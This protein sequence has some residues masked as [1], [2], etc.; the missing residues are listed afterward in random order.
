MRQAETGLPDTL[1]KQ[2][3]EAVNT[4][5]QLAPEL[6]AL[7]QRAGLTLEKAAK[8]SAGLDAEQ[9][10]TKS[11]LS[12][13]WNGKR[14]VPRRK[15]ETL[16]ALCRVPL[17]QR[18][19]FVRA[20]E[21]AETADVAHPARGTLVENADARLLGVHASI[22][23]DGQT[24]D[25]PAYVT[26]D[27][28]E[29]IR[30][31]LSAAGQQATFVLLMGDSSTG[32]TRTLFEALQAVLPGWWLL[33]PGHPDQI[34]EVAVRP[35]A[36]TVLWLDELQKYL[37][38]PQRLTAA[39]VRTLLGAGVV[40]VASLWS[41]Y[42]NQISAV[43]TDDGRQLLRLAQSLLMPAGFS[44]AERA[45]AHQTAETDPRLRI[46][47]AAHDAG[48]TQTLA[49]GPELLMRWEHATDP[50]ATAVITAAVDARRLGMESPLTAAHLRD[51]VPGYLS[52]AQR[53][54]AGDDWLERA[55]A[56][57]TV[58]VHRAAGTLSAHREAMTGPPDGYRA[59][60]FL[61][62]QS[63][64]TRRT[65]VLP[66]SF[67]TV[68]AQH[69][70]NP[71]DLRRLAYQAD[72][73]ARRRHA[74]ALYERLA[75]LGDPAAASRLADL[76]A[77]E[78][79]SQAQ[80]ILRQHADDQ[81]THA[82]INH[83]RAALADL[84]GLRQAATGGD[85]VAHC[86]LIGVLAA[87]DLA[88]VHAMA[89]EGDRL[90]R[91]WLIDH[92]GGPE[93]RRTLL[94]RAER[95]DRIARGRLAEVLTERGHSSQAL[96]VLTSA[97]NDGDVLAA[98]HRAD[99]L[100]RLS[101]SAELLALAD[102]GDHAAGLAEDTRL[103]RGGHL[104]C[105]IAGALADTGETDQAIAVLQAHADGLVELTDDYLIDLLVH[106]ERL[107]LL[108]QIAATGEWTSNRR[109]AELAD[110][111]GDLDALHRMEAG[112]NWFA[113]SLLADRMLANGRV[114]EAI[115]HLSHR[116][117]AGDDF[118]KG[119]LPDLLAEHGREYEL[120]TL[121]RTDTWF[122]SGRWATYLAGTGR[123][124]QAEAWLRTQQGPG[125][126]LAASQLADLLV[127]QGR[128]DDALDVLRPFT[129][130]YGGAATHT[131]V[132]LLHRHGRIAE[133]R[134][135]VNAG[136][137]GAL[138]RLLQLLL[139]AGTITVAE[140]EQVRRRGLSDGWPDDNSEP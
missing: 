30:E 105:R 43:E 9:V 139:R 32:K 110:A 65:T 75:A 123:S 50:C 4:H 24:G 124:E 116:A 40:I 37:D 127:A 94:E 103:P 86:Q 112:G 6:R 87:N 136:T 106:L 2:R 107:D 63:F 79:M 53:A 78:D 68:L 135:E 96:A 109:L 58:L 92:D 20:W 69:A 93:H 84:D 77:A 3:L 113:T 90:A 72:A 41:G 12:A 25:L 16:L 111:R 104:A 125:E 60:D 31:L 100:V 14:P 17:Q 59:A 131:L 70:R 119:R 57:S 71:E 36:R 13:Y 23:V 128:I 117:S 47:V 66:T 5:G 15:L 52:S 11:A 38:G 34:R 64:R 138:E 42:Y 82:K 49:A 22:V 115:A 21:R 98:G 74:A 51:A 133:L 80:T 33:H 102:A 8:Q 134:A 120:E 48:V 61:L 140:V 19:W 67:W 91:A 76:T 122:A 126:D 83:W 137:S 97:A 62:Q 56:Y 88:Q 130:G 26:R 132:E 27:V 121:A 45:R 44:A 89:A 18:S 1:I 35:A 108:E 29:Q 129:I 73:R 101:R 85:L 99:L 81:H 28:D 114:D 46:A 10:L 54:A 39:T 55:L 118:A 95:G 7:C